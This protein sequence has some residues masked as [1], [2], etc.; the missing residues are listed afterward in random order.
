[1]THGTHSGRL[2]R[3]CAAIVAAVALTRCGDT[4]AS[5]AQIGEARRLS[6]DLLVE[7]TKA[8]D[9][10]NRAVLADT[11]PAAIASVREAEA[12][13]QAVDKDAQLLRPILTGHGY[14]DETHLLDEFV[15]RFA[16]YKALDRRILDLAVEN[17]NLKAQQLS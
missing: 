5:F 8:S 1:M 13:T 14:A 6:A 4:N 17:T 11:D 10:A 9:A 16:D 2:T 12:A 3:I 15:A 7:F